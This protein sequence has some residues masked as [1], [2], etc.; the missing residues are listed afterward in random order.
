M[1]SR[2]ARIAVIW[3]LVLL[4]IWLGERLY[5]NYVWK[6]DPPHIVNAAGKLS[7]W[8]KTNIDLFLS[9][10]PSVVSITTEQLRVNPFMGAEVAQGAGSGFVWDAAGH[11][12][13]NFHVVE[14]ANIGYVQLHHGDP[15]R[16]RV[17]GGA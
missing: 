10:A 15:I 4:T 1:G 7:D 17:V 11:I 5:R 2:S 14:G 8:E 12:V 3:A 13:T 9:A 16:A 6:A